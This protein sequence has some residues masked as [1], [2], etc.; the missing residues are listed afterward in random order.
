MTLLAQRR[1]GRRVLQG[2][3]AGMQY[4]DNSIGSAYIPKLLGLYERELS[5]CV[6]AIDAIH[7]EHIIDIGAGEG[8]YAVGLALRN[9]AARMT[10]FEMQLAGRT[11]IAELA[12]LNRVEEQVEIRGECTIAELNRALTGVSRPVV[13][14]DVE[15]AELQLLDPSAAPALRD[16]AILVE[17]HEFVVRGITDEITKRFLDTHQIEHVWQEPRS[18]TEFPW[19]TLRTSLLPKSY[20]DWAVSEW[21]PE[22][23]AWLWM[24][25]KR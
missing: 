15:G 14:C 10:A 13:V 8:Y 11:A 3:F 18:R 24:R 16:A 1:T 21:R 4:V 5:H 7:P 23:M 9:P 17:L 22:R 6:E 20:L 2:P 25:P 19:R 12:R